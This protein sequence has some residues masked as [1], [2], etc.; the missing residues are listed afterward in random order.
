MNRFILKVWSI[1][2][3]G[4][5]ALSCNK[6]DCVNSEPIFD[7]FAPETKEYQV[8]LAKAIAKSK[9]PLTYTL[10]RVTGN[11]NKGILL[12]HVVGDSLCAQALV[13]YQSNYK[14]LEPVIANQ[15]K[16]YSGAELKGVLM[17]LKAT[18][19]SAYFI[20]KSVQAVVD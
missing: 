15:G 11:K 20:F 8:A 7:V 4:I 12:I 17:D 16:G 9:T 5:I 18:D 3:F 10:E 2:V 19:S 14:G 6:T 1:F 13:Q